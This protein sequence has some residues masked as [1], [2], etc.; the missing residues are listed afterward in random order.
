[1]LRAGNQVLKVES[2]GFPFRTLDPFL[3]AVYHDDKYP[4]GNGSMGPDTKELLGVLPPAFHCQTVVHT[5]ES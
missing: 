5:I 2:L 4:S 1:M 3:F